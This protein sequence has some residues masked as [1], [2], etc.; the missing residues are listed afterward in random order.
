MRSCSG[1]PGHGHIPVLLLRAASLAVPGVLGDE[2][3]PMREH[4]LRVPPVR[5]LLVFLDARAAAGERAAARVARQP[6]TP[7]EGCGAEDRKSSSP[8]RYQQHHVGFLSRSTAWEPLRPGAG[9][10]MLS[11]ASPGASTALVGGTRAPPFSEGGPGVARACPPPVT[12]HAPAQAQAKRGTSPP[13]RLGLLPYSSCG[14]GP[15]FLLSFR[16]VGSVVSAVYRPVERASF[17]AVACPRTQPA[18][19]TLGLPLSRR[20]VS[21]WPALG[22]GRARS[23]VAARFVIP[24]DLDPVRRS[25]DGVAEAPA[26][27]AFSS[28]SASTSKGASSIATCASPPIPRALAS[29]LTR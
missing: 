21:S 10:G 8:Q 1:R 20:S 11:P 23:I 28:L 22:G 14:L 18:V 29:A 17:V 25:G 26:V 15:L 19:V 24:L 5:R 13:L 27:A 16:R 4:A 7:A 6:R 12:E 3:R 2:P 9:L